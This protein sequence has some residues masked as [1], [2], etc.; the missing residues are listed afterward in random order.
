[1]RSRVLD[2]SDADRVRAL[3]AADPV[4]HCFVASRVA[5]GVLEPGTPGELW[6]YPAHAPTSLLHVG[7]NCVPVALTPD[8]RRAFVEDLG[9]YRPFVS[10]VGPAAEALGLFDALSERWGDAYRRCRAVRRRQP[11]MAIGGRCL[12]EPDPRV[13]PATMRWFESYFEGAVAM[14]TEELGESPLRANPVGYRSYVTTLIESGKAFAIVVDDEVIFKADIGAVGGGVAQVQGVWVRPEFRGQGLAAPAMA[15]VTN[16]ITAAGRIASL[17]VN[18][19]NHAAIATYRRCG[20]AVVGEFASI[21][22]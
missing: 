22:Y 17:Y 14:Y 4:R 15:A 6:G 12:V 7:A 18:D 3:C 13:T 20:Y 5:A 9:P 16:T 2:V 19:F 11:L 8:A 21:L 10:I 1:M